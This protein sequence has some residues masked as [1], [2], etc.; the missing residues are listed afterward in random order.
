MRLGQSACEIHPLLSDPELR[1]ALVPLVEAEWEV[2]QLEAAAMDVPENIAGAELRDRR[3]THAILMFS[4]RHPGD[5]KERVYQTPDEVADDLE[6]T[7]VNFLI[8]AYYEMVDQSSPAITGMTPERMDELKKALME[9][10]WSAVSGKSW[11]ALR[12]FLSSV[13]TGPLLDS[14]LGSTSTSSLTTLSE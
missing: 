9:M 10:D 14:L 13:G 1:F 3:Q 8:D 7:D 6:V 11:Y 4:I 5:L 2:A 12:R